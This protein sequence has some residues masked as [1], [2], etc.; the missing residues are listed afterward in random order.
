MTY[1]RV[2]TFYARGPR[3]YGRIIEVLPSYTRARYWGIDYYLYGGVYYRRLGTSY[4]ITRPPFGVLFDRA[5]YELELVACNFA[6]VNTVYNTYT[7]IDANYATIQE[8][9]KIIAENNALIASQQATIAAQ[10]EM[11]NSSRNLASASA[12]LA[13]K[14]GLVQ[15]YAA[16]GTEYFYDDG[17]FF[18]TGANDQYLV[19]VPPAGA[20][21]KNLPDDYEVITLDGV[22]YYR[23]DDTVY[24]M[25]VSEGTPYFEVI[26]QMPSQMAAKYQN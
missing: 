3:H 18:T 1:E 8:Q 22:E 13:Q 23:V 15:S 9:N 17:V 4:Y 12:S 14:L 20:L 16:A 5:L 25:T 19:I 24:K 2:H 10:Q 21:V 26:G 11:L 6:F 7:T